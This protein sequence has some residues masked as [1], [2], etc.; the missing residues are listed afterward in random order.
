MFIMC[1]LLNQVYHPPHAM[2][3]HPL[4]GAKL[5]FETHVLRPCGQLVVFH[6]YYELELKRLGLLHLRQMGSYSKQEADAEIS[7]VRGK[8]EGGPGQVCFMCV[9]WGHAQSRRQ[10]GAGE[11]WGRG[12]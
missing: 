7:R 2:L 3:A 1:P 5:R 11:T 6:E 8:Q 10:T 9:R 4:V 12:F